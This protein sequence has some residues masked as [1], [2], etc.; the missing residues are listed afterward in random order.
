MRFRTSLLLLVL[1]PSLAAAQSTA[2]RVDTLVRQYH[3]LGQINGA[4]LVAESGEI[5]YEE[6]VGEADMTFGVANTADTRFL[7]GS[8]TKN[9]TGALILQLVEEGAV[10]L[11]APLSTYLPDYPA[12]VGDRVTVHHLLTHSSGI[13][14]YTGLPEFRTT[15]VANPQTPESL[16]DYVKDRELEF[17]PGAEFRYNNSG[18]VLL[19]MIVEAVTGK[20]WAEA[21]EERILDPLGMETAG[22]YD[23]REIVPDL[24]D[25]YH[26]TPAGYVHAKPWNMTAAHAAGA[27]YGTPRD[28]WVWD[29]ALAEE[30]VFEDAATYDL[31][32]GPHLDGYGYGWLVKNEEVGDE[33]VR[34]VEH[35]GGLDGFITGFRRFPDDGHLIVVTDNTAGEVYALVNGITQILYGEAAPA[36]VPSIATAI[37]PIVETQDYEAVRSE[38][39]RLKEEEPEGYD[40]GEGELNAL[41]YVYLRDGDVETATD[42]FRL[43]VEA[44]PEAFNPWDSLGEGYMVAGDTAQAVANYQTS[45]ELN[46]ANENA[47][48]MLRAMGAEVGEE[49]ETV[50]LAPEVLERYAGTYQLQ[51]GFTIEVTREG[52]RLF[53]QATGQPRF[54]MFAQSE[55]RFFLKAVDAQVEFHDYEDGRADTFTLFQNGEHT[56]TRVES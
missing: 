49:A 39:L 20:P 40:F 10:D 43:N 24:A 55:D 53:G 35:D 32:Y 42:V 16:I 38:Y 21:L 36:P 33:R 56:L 18:Y 28:L 5:I 19:G 54:E 26:H 25:G 44:F 51:P 29:R 37:R 15:I 47:R 9:F 12:E 34:I 7:I 8:V 2:E 22:V 23:S 14:S 31:F 48:R 45:L 41:G 1:L 52:D 4:V 3:D 17:E 27:M 6:G 50:E 13:P 46:P 30:R 11:Q